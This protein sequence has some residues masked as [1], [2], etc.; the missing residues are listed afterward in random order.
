MSTTR[1]KIQC[2]ECVGNTGFMWAFLLVS[3]Q[4][5][6][7]N[8]NFSI[9]FSMFQNIPHNFAGKL[10]AVPGIR[11]EQFTGCVLIKNVFLGYFGIEKYGES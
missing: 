4:K 11:V 1:W 3:Y 2:L 10:P 7:K 9:L 6:I 5:S 8:A